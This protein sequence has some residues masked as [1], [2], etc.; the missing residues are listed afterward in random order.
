MALATRAGAW[1]GFTRLVVV[2][3]ATAVS[4]KLAT[5][6]MIVLPFLLLNSRNLRMRHRAMIMVSATPEPGVKHHAEESQEFCGTM[7]HEQPLENNY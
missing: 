7:K 5:A 1:F 4:V 2:R 6:W 3:I